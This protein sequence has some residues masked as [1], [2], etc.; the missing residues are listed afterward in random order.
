M[1]YVLPIIYFL[2]VYTAMYHV[3]KYNSDVPAKEKVVNGPSLSTPYKKDVNEEMSSESKLSTNVDIILPPAPAA[4]DGKTLPKQT[5]PLN[6]ESAATIVPAPKENSLSEQNRKV[7]NVAESPEKQGSAPIG[8]I[9]S[10][11]ENAMPSIPIGT[12]KTSE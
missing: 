7:N 11:K 6:E 2:M 5:P 1:F 10:P 3:P 8:E 4:N 12:E 9:D